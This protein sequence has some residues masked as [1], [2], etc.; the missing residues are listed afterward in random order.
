M[1]EEEIGGYHINLITGVNGS[2]KTTVLVTIY[3]MFQ[4]EDL[5]Q[6][7]D[8][9]ESEEISQ[10]ILDIKNNDDNLKIKKRYAN[11]QNEIVFSTFNDIDKISKIDRKKVFLWSGED[12]LELKARLKRK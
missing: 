5:F 8:T 3:S 2:G 6:Y 12:S 4:Y 1:R 10:I 7:N 11:G 9:S